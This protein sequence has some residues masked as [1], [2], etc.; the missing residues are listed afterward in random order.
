[1]KVSVTLTAARHRRHIAGQEIFKRSLVNGR[2]TGG[3]TP[4]KGVCSGSCHTSGA[5][6]CGLSSQHVP[7]RVDIKH[8]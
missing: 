6:Q 4:I 8:P 7:W 5:I 3:T 1:M 2:Q